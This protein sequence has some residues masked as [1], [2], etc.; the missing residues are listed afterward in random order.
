MP[1]AQ[2]KRD[3]QKWRLI[4][5]ENIEAPFSMVKRLKVRSLCDYSLNIWLT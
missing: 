5:E 2:F 1:G 3:A 4:A